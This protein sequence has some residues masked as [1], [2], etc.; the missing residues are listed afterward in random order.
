MKKINIGD[1]VGD[2][3]ILETLGQGGNGSVFKACNIDGSQ[4]AIKVFNTEKNQKVRY[5]RFKDEIDII[6]RNGDLKGILPILDYDL[7]EKSSESTWYA[8]P[9]AKPL[10]NL[11]EN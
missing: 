2:W 8:M 3:T 10:I 6:R 9:L 11:I 1:K 7:P 5:K 4:A